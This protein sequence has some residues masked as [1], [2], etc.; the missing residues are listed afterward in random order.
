MVSFYATTIASSQNGCVG[1]S[2]W[3]KLHA[4]SSRLI[5]AFAQSID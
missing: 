1:F 5:E 2:D 3:R 4:V